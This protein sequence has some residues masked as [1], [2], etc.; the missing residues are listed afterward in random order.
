LNS[1]SGG[2]IVLVAT[3]LFGLVW[4]LRSARAMSA[5]PA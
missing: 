5:A 1:A 3:A 4:L 2:T